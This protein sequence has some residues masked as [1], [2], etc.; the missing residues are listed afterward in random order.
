MHPLVGLGNPGDEYSETRHNIG[1]MVV[2][3]RRRLGALPRIEFQARLARGRLQMNR[4]CSWK[5]QG[6]NL[7]RICGAVCRVLPDFD[8]EYRRLPR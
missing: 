1:F 4:A 6:F 3:A 7:W 8:E 5:P 2:D